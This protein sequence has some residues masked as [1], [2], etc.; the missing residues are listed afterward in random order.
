MTIS[1]DDQIAFPRL[2]DDLW[3]VQQGLVPQVDA[4]LDVGG[5]LGHLIGGVPK[6]VR[7]ML[8]LMSSYLF[9]EPDAPASARVID[10]AIATEFLHVGT[11]CHDDVMDEAASRRGRESVNARWGNAMAILVGDHLLA[12]AAEIAARLGAAESRI[13]AATFRALCEG[14][15][16]ETLHL[17]DKARSEELYYQAITGKT[18]VLISAACRLGAMNAG[19]QLEQVEALAEFGLNFGIAFQINDDVLDL[20]QTAERLGKP[21]GQDIAEGVYTLPTISAATQVKE[22]ATLLGRPGREKAERARELVLAS[23]TVQYCSDAARHHLGLAAAALDRSAAP[24][25][26]AQGIFG[27]ARGTLNTVGLADAAGEALFYPYKQ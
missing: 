16:C 18:A 25:N 1:T 10:S 11:M 12:N 19:A 14:Q 15:L 3:R 7:P 5:M 8:V 20:V 9:A 24:D 23:G 17:Y 2:A 6:L 4:R 26:G 22:L 27:F 13:I 21:A